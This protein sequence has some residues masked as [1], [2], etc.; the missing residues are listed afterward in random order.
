LFH[1]IPLQ[2]SSFSDGFASQIQ[3]LTCPPPTNQTQEPNIHDRTAP[4]WH[5]SR[6]GEN[7]GRLLPHV[8]PRYQ[9]RL[10]IFKTSSSMRLF[11]ES[12]I[13]RS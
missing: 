12:V 9:I 13:K 3:T 7:K 11:R 1:A 4:I 6:Q 2:S 8:V 5:H 10:L